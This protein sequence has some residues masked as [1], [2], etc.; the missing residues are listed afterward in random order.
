[1]KVKIVE[2]TSPKILEAH[3]NK[4]IETIEAM[5]GDIM[6][7]KYI[8]VFDEEYDNGTKV[9]GGTSYSAMIV[10]SEFDPSE[11]AD[12]NIDWNYETQKLYQSPHISISI[13]LPGVWEAS[14]DD[15]QAQGINS[16]LLCL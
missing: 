14:Q 1:M 2:S 7:I 9:A 16:G 3:I 8:P 12:N 6:D 4:F 15:C 5:S 11:I 13:Y 10:Y